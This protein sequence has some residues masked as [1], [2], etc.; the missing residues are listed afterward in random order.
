LD[1]FCL[2]HGPH[3]STLTTTRQGAEHGCATVRTHAR[4][5]P[6]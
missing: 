1:R 2:A 3:V 5:D 6:R 4:Q